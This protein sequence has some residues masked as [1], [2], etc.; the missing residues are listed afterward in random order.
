MGTPRTYVNNILFLLADHDEIEKMELTGVQ[1]LALNQLVKDLDD[2]ASYLTALSPTQ[3][4]RLNLMRKEAELYIKIAIVVCF[5]HI[6]LGSEQSDLQHVGS[7]RPMRIHSMRVTDAEA[8][9]AITTQRSQDESIVQYLVDAGL[10]RTTNEKELSPEFII[11]QLWDKQKEAIPADEFKA[12]FYRQPSCGIIFSDDLIKRSLRSGLEKGRWLV[13][14]EGELYDVKNSVQFRSGLTNDVQIVLMSTE[15]ARTLIEQ[16]FCGKCK[17]RRPCGCDETVCEVCGQRKRECTCKEQCDRCHR[18]KEDCICA[19]AIVV[20]EATLTRAAK[21][22]GDMLRDRDIDSLSMVR[23]RPDGRRA[24]LNLNMAMPQ[25]GKVEKRFD[26]AFNINQPAIGN[27]LK[28][29]FHGNE[30]G[31]AQLKQMLSNYEGKADFSSYD[32]CLELRFPEGVR[33]SE[34]LEL[35]QEKV[36]QYTGEELYAVELVPKREGKA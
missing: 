9:S 28:V 29:E 26:I 34:L 31:Y 1:Y 22:L 8:R 19:D 35:L 36:H 12:T 20:K 30:M 32:L 11:E 10:G 21:D 6:V 25:F 3:R 7:R 2:G 27:L 18:P 13:L 17:Q 24:L 23:I 4:Q 16:Y 15:T 33:S 14:A 5:R